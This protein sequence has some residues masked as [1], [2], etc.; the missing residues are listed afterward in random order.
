MKNENGK[1]IWL[2][3]G[4]ELTKNFL[5]LNLL[6][7]LQLSVHPIILG[8]GKLLFNEIQ[9]KINLILIDE[10]KYSSGLIQLIYKIEN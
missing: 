6:D 7:E 3:G 5:N 10:K 9:N 2:F 8:K 4:A 1:N